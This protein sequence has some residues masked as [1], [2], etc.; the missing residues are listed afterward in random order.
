MRTFNV[1]RRSSRLAL[2]IATVL[3]TPG[4]VAAESQLVRVPAASIEML[5]EHARLIDRHGDIAVAEIGAGREADIPDAVVLSDGYRLS[6]PGIPAADPLQRAPGP[7]LGSSDPEQPVIGLVQFRGP[8]KADWLTG[9]E[10]HGVSIAQHLHPFT[11]IVWASPA[12][13]TGARAGIEG[14]R[15][16]GLHPIESRVQAPSARPGVAQAFRVLTLRAADIDAA[17]LT[18]TGARIEGRRATDSKF[19]E[20][21]V[22]ASG[23]LLPALAAVPGVLSVQ[24]I[25]TDGGTR[26]EISNQQFAGNV[27]A[28][29][30]PLANYPN[31]L[32][33]FGLTGAGVVMANVDSGISETHPDVANRMLPCAGTSCGG[34][35]SSHGTHTAAIMAGDGASG[36]RDTRGFL[37]GLGVAPGANLIEQSYSPTFTQAGGMLT[38]MRVSAANGAVLSGNSWGPAA[39]PRGYDA[40]TRQVDVGVRDTNPDVAGDQPLMF[41]LSIMNGNGGTSTQGTPDEAKNTLTVGSTNSQASSTGAPLAT[42]Q[43]I[44]PN[45]GHGPALDGRLI[46]HLVAPGCRVDSASTSNGYALLCGTSMASPHVAGAAGLLIEAIRQREARTPSP[47]LVKA[48]FVASTVDLFGGTDANGNA[49]T[50]RP[51]PR[52]GW[53][54]MRLGTALGAVDRTW[55]HDQVHVF[56]ATGQSWTVDLEPRD[57]TQPVRVMLTWTDAPGHG[58]CASATCT[59][60]AW[61]NDLDLEIE[62]GASTWRGNVFGT[63]GWSTTGGSPDQRNNLEGV[64][65]P[66]GSPGGPFT[67]RVRAVNI[68]SDAL[69]NSPGALQQ[70]FALVCV[71]CRGLVPADP[72]LIFRDSFGD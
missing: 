25:P 11:Y 17:A 60:P 37:R 47:A 40:D 6:L 1:N 44:S 35:S 43:S 58:T 15:W 20:I 66:A 55:R 42:W 62:R 38:L 29:N 56:T 59:T 12:A 72:S 34:G 39:S 16:I 7:E 64:L 14:V 41:V 2:S 32:A 36:V 26:G 54:A 67:V 70:D 68:N 18:A 69:P 8:P 22:R 21:L 33:Q 50:R 51:N 31:W 71:N 61:N 19:E 65:L 27:D 9:L 3:L 49:L 23:E 57:S 52:Q 24:D 53:G 30:Q 46:P 4:V 5:P 28:G 45:S 48:H 63:D 10:E 13:L